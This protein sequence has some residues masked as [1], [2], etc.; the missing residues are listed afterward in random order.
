MLTVSIGIC[1]KTHRTMSL[2]LNQMDLRLTCTEEVPRFHFEPSLHY[3]FFP[4]FLSQ[5][6]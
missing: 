1:E 6:G 4:A 3:T 2:G 5:S